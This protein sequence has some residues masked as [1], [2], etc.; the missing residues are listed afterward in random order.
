MKNLYKI[1]L[2]AFLILCNVMIVAQGPPPPPG[3]NQGPT[4]PESAAAPIDM[5]VVI[6]AFAAVAFIILYARKSLAK[7][8]H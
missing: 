1:F 6:L 5:Y 3:G 7:Q 8:I 2:P 4:T